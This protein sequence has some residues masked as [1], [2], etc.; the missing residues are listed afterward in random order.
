MPG[1]IYQVVLTNREL[2]AAGGLGSGAGHP[3]PGLK[4]VPVE[5]FAAR[6]ERVADA[7]MGRGSGLRT[8]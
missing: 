8:C 2:G 7:K 3:L 6:K 5:L 4:R 1:L